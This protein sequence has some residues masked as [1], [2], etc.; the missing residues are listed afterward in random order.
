[1]VVLTPVR[2]HMLTH[3]FGDDTIRVPGGF[4]SSDPHQMESRDFVESV[5]DVEF[6][7]NL[8]D[9][10]YQDGFVCVSVCGKRTILFEPDKC[11]GSW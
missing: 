3:I 10:V 11:G 6:L 7:D 9:V 8:V 4:S 1:M 2:P 5:S